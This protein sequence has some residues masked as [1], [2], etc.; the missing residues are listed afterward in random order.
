MKTAGGVLVLVAGVLGIL[1]NFFWG[2]F[3]AA[4]AGALEGQA[5]AE[6]AQSGYAAMAGLSALGG[7]FAILLATFGIVILASGRQWPG[8][9]AASLA[10]IYIF[11]GSPVTGAIAI[12]G[13][14]LAILGARKRNAPASTNPA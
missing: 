9:V 13:G 4:G 11:S 8:I 1:T 5:G 2:V 12:I 3:S 14:V 10:V 7:L 6:Q